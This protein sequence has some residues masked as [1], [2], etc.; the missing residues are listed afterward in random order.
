[1]KS[2]AHQNCFLCG[3]KNPSSLGLSFS[4][5][6]DGSVFASCLASEAHQ[7][8]DGI[9]HGGMVASLL[10]AAMTHCLFLQNIKAVTA[11]L[12]VRYLH[13]VPCGSSVM[14]YAHLAYKR[15]PF[16]RLEAELTVEDKISARS[17]AKFIANSIY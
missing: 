12:S 10:D 9:L 11:E 1:M 15:P 13:P 16:Y 5:T 4:K 3:A 8:Y 17:E 6:N 2:N 7:G 14:L